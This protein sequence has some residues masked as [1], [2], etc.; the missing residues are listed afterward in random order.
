VNL[1]QSR[2]QALSKMRTSF[3]MEPEI[4]SQ[5]VLDPSVTFLNHGSFGAC[6]RP[7]LEL[8]AEL[9]ARMERE[10]VRFFTH[11]LEPLLDEARAELGRFVGADAAD[12]GFV[13][14]ATTGVN[15]VL[16]SLRLQ[17]GDE[18]VCTDHG[19]NAC[20]NALRRW[21]ER[22]GA[23]V[24]VASL[25]F[26]LPGEQAAVDAVLAAVTPRTRL[27]LIDHVTS[28]TGMVLPVARLVPALAQRGIDTLVDGAHAPGMLP[29][30]LRKLGAAYYTGNL[31]KWCCAPK[32]AG[33]LYVRRDRQEGLHPS[34]TSHGANSPRRDKPRF[35]L[36][37]DWVGTDDYTAMLCVPAALRFLG[38]VFPGGWPELMQRNRTLALSAR[39]KLAAALG[40]RPPCPDELIG[41]LAA[42]P[43]PDGE[44]VLQARLYERHRIEVPIIPWPAP[45]H[46]LVR[47]SAQIYNR[48]EEYEQLGK[49][50]RA[51]LGA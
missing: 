10:P 48:I 49:A 11:D 12:L 43:L 4:R 23:R 38:R 41:T 39:R 21:A 30:E 18:L 7:V 20:N 44:L 27:A 3:G 50:L 22:S 19:Y 32:G 2:R 6:P 14:N 35:Q 33:F 28:P 37:L 42:L 5:F 29:L 26:P 17:P 36:E 51:E 13:R 25:P 15:S 16:S 31:H 46:R 34:V 8:Q 40:V 9:R 45:P 47:I 24:V 1:A